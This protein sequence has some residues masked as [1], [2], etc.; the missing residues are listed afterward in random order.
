MQSFF[1]SCLFLS[2][3]FAASGCYQQRYGY[4]AAKP[5]TPSLQKRGD[6]RLNASFS[7]GNARGAPEDNSKNLGFDVQGAYAV[8][9][10]VGVMA[11]V[12]GRRE[13]DVFGNGAFPRNN[14]F[15]FSVVDYKRRMAE[16]GIGYFGRPDTSTVFSI[17]GGTGA[18]RVSFDDLGRFDTVRAYTRR[19]AVNLRRYFLQPGFTYISRNRFSVDLSVRISWLKYGD[20]TSDYSADEK[21]DLGLLSLDR[22][23]FIAI[24]EPSVTFQVPLTKPG[25]LRFEAGWTSL[26]RPDELYARR[27]NFSAGFTA[28]PFLYFKRQQRTGSGQ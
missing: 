3:L 12:Y 2:L 15:G 18:G 23:P 17:Y 1:L 6:A 21:K 14:P 10:H 11:S 28:D 22:S 8:S 25:W 13:R 7:M 24:A 9:R 19:F 5:N 16:A 27:W 20:V 4:A 26:F